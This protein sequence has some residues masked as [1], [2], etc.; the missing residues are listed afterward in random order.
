[1]AS[2][3]SDTAERILSFIGKNNLNPGDI[4]PTQE[5]LC[6]ELSISI[7]KLREGL[8][9]L[10]AQGFVETRKKG[11]TI[12]LNP[13][14]DHLSNNV[15]RHL[16]TRGFSEAEL[17][18]ARAVFESAT[19]KET[20]KNRTARDLLNILNEIENLEK[21]HEKG[22]SDETADMKFHLELLKATHNPVLE[23]FGSL[24]VK[25]F[26]PKI[27]GGYLAPEET[28]KRTVIEHRKIFEAVQNQDA[29]RAEK[30][31][32]QHIIAPLE[33]RKVK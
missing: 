17:I 11:G 31:I 27:A 23:I 6:K 7:R 19:I 24:I 26:F 10:Q 15:V 1:M 18:K 22:V 29:R 2:N 8:S 5:E 12:V 3:S 32:Y 14:L 25:V 30:L 13:G 28:R 21:L 4:L 9:L 16:D 20:A 33:G